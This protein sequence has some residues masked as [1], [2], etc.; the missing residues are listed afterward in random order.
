MIPD[1]QYG[2]KLHRL[3]EDR[4][5]HPTSGGTHDYLV[6]E[7]LTESDGWL[8]L[9]AWRTTEEGPTFAGLANCLLAGVTNAS[10]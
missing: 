4:R 1:W 8:E 7:R 2:G 6:M 9:V 3:R 10:E 5:Q